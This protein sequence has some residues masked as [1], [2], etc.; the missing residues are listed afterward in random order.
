MRWRG[1]ASTIG[2]E[3]DCRLLT[4]RDVADFDAA[5]HICA[6]L[7]G[8]REHRLLHRQVKFYHGEGGC[9]EP[10]VNREVTWTPNGAG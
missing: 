3:L 9:L 7:C 8:G 1:L 2:L 5:P 10:A 4:R 6:S